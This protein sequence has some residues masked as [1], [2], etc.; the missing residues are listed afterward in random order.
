M[1]KQKAKVHTQRKMKANDWIRF[2]VHHKRELLVI[3]M[4]MNRIVFISDIVP[5]LKPALLCLHLYETNTIQSTYKSAR[6]ERLACK[7]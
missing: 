7:G 6:V 3:G 1:Y 4:K 2:L 5:Q